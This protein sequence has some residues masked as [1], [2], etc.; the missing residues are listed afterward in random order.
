MTAQCSSWS[1][2]TVSLPRELRA[3]IDFIRAANWELPA[4]TL[5]GPV[6][7]IDSLVALQPRR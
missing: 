4:A 3:F 6:T 1:G 2:R 7:S 5:A